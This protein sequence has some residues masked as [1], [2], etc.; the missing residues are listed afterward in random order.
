MP[1]GKYL[2]MLICL[3]PRTMFDPTKRGTNMDTEQTEA[4]MIEGVPADDRENPDTV[5]ELRRSSILRRLILMFLATVLP[6]FTLGIYIHNRGLETIQSE[7]SS[8][9]S[10]QAAFFMDAL[11]KEIERIRIL[12]YDC[13]NDEY[14]NKLAIRH[15]IMTDYEIVDSMVQLRL[16]LITILSSSPYVS[17]V[18]AHIP[19]IGRTISAKA[20][21][22]D[23]MKERFMQLYVPNSM[24]GAQI[25]NDERKLY[26]S[27]LHEW[28]SSSL[29]AIEIDLNVDA[30]REAL[31]QFETY[32]NSSSFLL[33]TASDDIITFRSADLAL[34]EETVLRD[35]TRKGIDR[36]TE[37]E[38]YFVVT[39][40]SDYLGMSLRR[41]IPKTTVMAPLR[42]FYR[43]VWTFSFV[44]GL[45]I[46]TYLIFVYRDI[47]RPL[48]DLV[49]TFRSVETGNFNVAVSARGRGEFAYLCRRFNMMVS[50]LGTLID[51][52]YRQRILT[53][54]AEMKQLQAQINPHFLYN[55]LFLIN[56]MA[57]VGD[58]HLIPFTQSLGEYFR[59]ITRS[60]MDEIPLSEELR[61]T[62]NYAEI[63]SMRFPKRLKLMLG[64][65]PEQYLDLRVPRLI[66]QPVLENAF[67]HAVEKKLSDS[68]V[69]MTFSP[70]PHGLAIVVEDNGNDMTDEKL[71]RL[72]RC[73]QDEQ[74]VG[75]TTGLINIHRRLRLEFDSESGLDVSRSELGGLRVTLALSRKEEN[76]YVPP[77]DRG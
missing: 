28:Q 16:R 53:H 1:E 8:S 46:L 31:N 65:C 49:R 76:A 66:L 14:L 69:R 56:T 60:G 39:A 45:M 64:E 2:Q 9:T 50:R 29:Y 41:Y 30:F 17:E 4:R 12:Q 62:R 7:I 51:Q 75:E 77:V 6:V 38:E 19:P 33:W 47:H 59:F 24:I 54:R 48:S 42:T 74:A 73:L 15:P 55:S 32:P 35:M 61:H 57:R 58:E 18:R 25:L 68:I 37:N 3:Y 70:L 23:L 10:A 43:W 40:K 63:Q 44:T 71:D 21:V 36:K 52:N 67:E 27:T 20:G 72:R 11:D 26:L 13:L 22:D 5:R 34:T